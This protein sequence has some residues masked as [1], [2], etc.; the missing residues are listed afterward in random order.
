MHAEWSA[1]GVSLWLALDANVL[2]RMQVIAQV[3]RQWVKGQ[4]VKL[5]SLSCNGRPLPIDESATPEP[6]NVD[7]ATRRL[8]KEKA[9]WP[10]AQ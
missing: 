5:I 9:P 1:E 6:T 3:V 2:D 4:G 7:H 10:S 8:P